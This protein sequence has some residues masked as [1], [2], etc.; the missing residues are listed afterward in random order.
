MIQN[1]PAQVRSRSAQNTLKLF[2]IF[3]PHQVT[4]AGSCCGGCCFQV[5]G[6]TQSIGGDGVLIFFFFPFFPQVCLPGW[7][8]CS[9]FCCASREREL[10][11]LRSLSHSRLTHA[12]T[13]VRG[14]LRQAYGI[15]G[16]ACNDCLI[17]FFCS[18]VRGERAAV[19]ERSLTNPRPGGATRA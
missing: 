3:A 17:G 6:V 10:K 7:A 8:D 11:S 12:H 5:S 16:S 19:S 15:Q 1:A 13:V 2:Q 14:S 9:A 18:C 4:C